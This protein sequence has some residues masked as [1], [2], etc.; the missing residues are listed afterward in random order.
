MTLDP[1]F[2]QF[3]ARLGQD[4]LLVQGAGGNVS[5]KD[6]TTLWI[7]ASGAWLAD[8]EKKNIF[9]AV[10]LK[11]IGSLIENDDFSSIPLLK[12]SP[13]PS[14]ETHLHAIMPQKVVVHIHAIEALAL[15][16]RK[17]FSSEIHTRMKGSSMEWMSLD[18]HT[19]GVPLAQALRQ[20][21]KIQPKVQVVFLKNHGLIVG[22]ESLSEAQDLITDISQRCQC[23]L[24]PIT[25]PPLP[26]S[27][28]PRVSPILVPKLHLLAQS[29][30]LFK[31]LEHNWVLYPDHAVFLGPQACVYKNGDDFRSNSKETGDVVFIQNSGVFV[32]SQFTSAKLAQLQCYFDVL[33]RQPHSTPLDPLSAEDTHFLL[34]W[35]AEKYRQQNS[36]SI[37]DSK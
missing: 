36:Q 24:M 29:Q 31:H 37:A 7:K 3:C 9:S 17:D 6:Q 5:L 30:D 18:Y 22:A 26:V 35:D 1:L 19:P 34:T 15:L 21:L 32:T 25:T 2:L 16:V 13:K 20:K 33:I 23:P 10:D 27:P 11:K 4:P 14:I 8:A 12:D 28:D